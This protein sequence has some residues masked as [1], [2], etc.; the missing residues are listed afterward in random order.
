MNLNFFTSFFILVS[1]FFFLEAKIPYEIDLLLK[2]RQSTY[3]FTSTSFLDAMKWQRSDSELSFIHDKD[4]QAVEKNFSLFCDQF[5]RLPKQDYSVI[6]QQFSIPPIIHLIWLGSDIPLQVASA[7]DTWKTHHPHWTIK[8]WTDQDLS[9]FI[10]TNKKVQ[11]AF[12]Q[13]TTWAEKAD[14]LRIELLYQFGGIYSDAD[15]VCLNS[16]QD[17]IVQNIG[18]FS[19]FELNYIGKHY[20]EP[21][22]VGSAVMGAAKNSAV[23][24]YCLENL[25]SVADAPQE[26]IIKRTGPGLISRACQAVLASGEEQVLILP[27]SYLYPLP[28][29]QRDVTREEIISYISPESLAIHLWDGSW[30]T[31]K[32][33]KN[34]QKCK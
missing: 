25:R 23:M 24:K 18:F 30:C 8:I 3:G 14:I 7:F 32:K 28:W 15:V 31:H 34:K 13:A 19:C 2:H 1:S 6:P 16:F 27:C 5:K 4:V 9:D 10:W 21:F 26:G 29:K 20:G 33:K 12:E 17:L 22:F 11:L